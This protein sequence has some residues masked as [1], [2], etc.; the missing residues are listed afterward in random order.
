MQLD[1]RSVQALIFD[2][3]GLLIDS[4]PTWFQ[5]EGAF[6][7]K[8]GFAWTRAEAEACMGQ[9]T[10]HTLQV[11]RDKHGIE[12]DVERDT[13]TILSE[14]IARAAEMPLKTGA[15]ELL[16]RARSLGLPMAVASSSRTRL[17]RAMLASKGIEPYFHI[18][19]SGQDVARGKPEPDIFLRAAELLGA[20]PSKCIVLE[21]ALAGVRAGVAAG[22]FVLAVPS[23]Q[24]PDFERCGARVVASL[25]DVSDWL[26]GV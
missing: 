18:V 5:V 17:I 10:P 7:A 2:L 26:G 15:L 8:F 4:E 22:C 24:S 6:L 23:V 20:S 13:E 11:W 16:D 25:R 3:D 9:G 12:I 19:V 14:V 21:D 1:P